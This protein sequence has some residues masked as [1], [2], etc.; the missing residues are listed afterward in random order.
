MGKLGNLHKNNNASTCMHCGK[1]LSGRRDKKFCDHFCKSA[2]HYRQMQDGQPEI[3]TFIDRQLKT[4]RKILKE[5][6]RAGKSTVRTEKLHEKG[7]NPKVF[8]HFW[9][10]RNGEAY[11]FVYEY[12]FMKRTEM[13]AGKKISKYV[14]I[15][16]QD[17]MDDTILK[18]E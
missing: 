7:F 2:Y 18:Q 9:K 16:W 6:N 11:L 15:T 8:T 5:F 4:N 14:L 12:G 10:N 1:P 13:K 17:Y 3:F